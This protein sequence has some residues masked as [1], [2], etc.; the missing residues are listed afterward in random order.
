M[1]RAESLN[2]GR[3]VVR[4]SCVG[5]AVSL[6]RRQLTPKSTRRAYVGLWLVCF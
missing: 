3:D 5:V 4:I 2:L 1:R 6:I